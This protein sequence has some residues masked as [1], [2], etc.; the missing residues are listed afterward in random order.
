M[1]HR[2]IAGIA[3][4]AAMLGLAACGSSGSSSATTGTTAADATKSVDAVSVDV[5]HLD[6]SQSSASANITAAP[7]TAKSF[8]STVGDSSRAGCELD[9]LKDEGIRIGRETDAILCYLGTAQ[10]NV[11]AFVVDATQRFYNVTAPVGKSGS[12]KANMTFLMRVQKSGGTLTMDMCNGGKLSEELAVTQSGSTVTAIG[13]H[14]FKG[15]SGGPGGGFE[16]KGGF[17][18]TLGLKSD[19]SGD[20]SYADIDSGSLVANFN[21]NYGRGRMTFSKTSNQDLND[22]TGVFVASFG[23]S[24]SFTGQIAG[25]TDATKGAVKYAVTGTFPAIAATFLPSPVRTLAT[26]GFCPASNMD[27]CN[28]KTNFSSGGACFGVSPTLACMCMEAAGASGLCTF[29]DSG[30]E[31]FS[32]STNA[33]TGA[34]TFLI[35]AANDYQTAVAAMTLP[36]ASDILTPAAT[37]GWDCS[38][39]G[40]TVTSI[41][42]TS[43]DFTACDS[44]VSRGFD[45]SAHSSCHES[46]SKDK[47]GTSIE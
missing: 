20:I 37:R 14:Y 2:H 36:A 19:A 46:E 38:T 47:A 16:D 23:S 26:N 7:K 45:D 8:G 17:D 32:M 22:A 24:N 33:T 29:T 21:G 41:D 30:T 25:R 6:A 28:P 43:L 40:Q 5:T 10:D 3:A 15:S 31:S 9:Q 12:S 4:V 18:L 39:T 1:L 44:K 34:Q 35:T 11:S 27:S 13:Y 42:V